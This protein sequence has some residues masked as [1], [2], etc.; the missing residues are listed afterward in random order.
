MADAA[1][2]AGQDQRFPVCIVN[3]GHGRNLVEG[4]GQRQRHG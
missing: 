1:A 3:L 2:R 4:V